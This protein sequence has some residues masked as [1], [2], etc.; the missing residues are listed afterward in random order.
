M[1][2]WELGNERSPGE[3]EK[4]K[5]WDRKGSWEKQVRGELFFQLETYA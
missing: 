4:E 2:K 3:S 1:Y 5:M